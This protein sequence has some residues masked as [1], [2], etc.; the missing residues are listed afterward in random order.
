MASV[1]EIGRLYGPL[2]RRFEN[3]DLLTNA[4]PLLAH[5]TSI[6]VMQKILEHEEVWFSNPLFMNDWEEMRFGMIEGSRIVTDQANLL[7][8][9]ETLERA[10]AIEQHY[11]AYQ[12]KYQN[13][14][15]F[16]TYIFCLSQHRPT[17]NDGLL[18]MWRGYGGQ[19]RGAAIVFD[20][21]KLTLVPNSP[22]LIAKVS[23]A[24]TPDR[25][26]DLA[27]LVAQWSDL[28]RAAKLPTEQL[29]VAGWHAY[30]AVLTYA[31][32]TKHL[33]FGEE[34]EWRVIYTAD[35]DVSGLLRHC[36]GY[37]ITD[38]GVEPK[39]K[40]RIGHIATVSAPDLALQNL[41]DRIILGP[42]LSSLLASKSVARMFENMR[43]PHYISKLRS[44]SIPFRPTDRL[45]VRR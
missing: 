3:M 13:E 10:A 43:K 31:L 7:Q 26:A 6:D 28:T 22:L 9:G 23:Y 17:D 18:S 32:T 16:D 12:Q 45:H 33:G 35:R 14:G 39:L 38:N 42:S 27:A 37:Q 19:G 21:G 30:S 29:H 15:A 1:E 4:P 24:S 8:A 25:L 5:Y 44:S 40:Y 36:L 34:E 11:N 2:Y 41:V 20:A